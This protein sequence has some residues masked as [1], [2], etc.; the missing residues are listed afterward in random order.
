MNGVI[1]NF[2]SMLLVSVSLATSS[3]AAS[4]SDTQG[5]SL[6]LMLFIGFFALIVVFQLVPAVLLFVGI[7][8][9]LFSHEHGVE[10]KNSN[11]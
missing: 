11:R 3:S 1:R 4:A 7:I 6:L 5:G 2:V 8:K 10:Q 9:G